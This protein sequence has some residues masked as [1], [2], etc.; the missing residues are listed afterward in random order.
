M[1]ILPAIDL[2]DG[3]CVRLLQGDYDRQIDY[4]PDP[5]VRARA[6]EAAGATWLH[7]VDLD[8]AKQGRPCN[9]DTIARIAQNTSLKLEVGGGVR[10]A[11]HVQALL[12]AGV[13]R[14]VMGTRALEDFAWFEQLVHTPAF[15]DRIVLGL[16]A[17]NGRVATR[18]WTETTALDAV[19][20]AEKVNDWP[21]AAIV[22]TDIAKDGMLA[23]PN[24]DAT[25]RLAQATRI[26]VVA[27][28]G[29][30]TLN[31][32]KAL[33][34]LPLGGIIIGRALY[35]GTLDLKDVLDLAAL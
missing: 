16:D 22:Y 4:D 11:D 18:G 1:D 13:T 28:G 30:T 26:P 19:D 23:G 6:F 29:V 20:L 12:D 7:C 15:A 33:L 8:G 3:H 9:H 5:L 10:N 32:I 25:H 31:D 14:V 24:L 2:R 34:Q 21:L 27:S 17:R 35:E